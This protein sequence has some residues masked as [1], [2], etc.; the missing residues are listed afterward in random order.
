MLTVF[1]RARLS[2]AGIAGTTFNPAGIAA[3]NAGRTFAAAVIRG[4]CAIAFPPR[5]W[6]F[7]LRSL[8]K[9]PSRFAKP[10]RIWLLTC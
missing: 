1:Q 10:T 4:R 8:T 7:A 9:Y 3:R 2:R 6:I 5:R